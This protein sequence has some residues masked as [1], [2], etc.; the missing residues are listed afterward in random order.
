MKRVLGWLV[1]I[2]VI[3][4][5]V[6]GVVLLTADDEDG[7]DEQVIVIDEV[8]RATLSDTVIVRGNVAREDR[9]TLNA[10][11][12][13]R[14]TGLGTEVDAEVAAGDEIL[15]LDGRPM[16][17]VNGETPY[18]RPLD[19][20]VTD[21]PDVETLEQFLLDAG[22]D[23]GTVNQEFS[24][25]TEDALEDWQEDNGYPVDG[26]FLPT[27]LAVQQWPATVGEVAVDVGDSVGPGQPLIGF[28][29]AELAVTIRVDPTDRS[30][31]DAGLPALITVTASD[32]EAPG[33]VSELEDAPTVDGQGV[34]RYRGEVAITGDLDLV[35]GAA[36]RV[37]VTL[38]EVIDALVV[39]VA[40]VSLNGSGV[41]EV[42]ILAADGT[43]ER[44]PVVT[45]LTEGALVEITDG[46]DGSEQVVVEVRQ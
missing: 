33:T 5:V 46:L 8:G 21:G 40:S 7:V 3:G 29:D 15:R 39:P 38:A 26:R 13:Q 31:L 20:F 43:I 10:L 1:A 9:F 23:P 45:G 16:L 12:P 4:A 35:E 19:R 32:V 25:V 41:E 28:V 18:W 42:R 14:V 37:E 24:T 11:T 17:A 30:R 2:A 44:V 34:E 36:V 27:D 6:Y 22:Y